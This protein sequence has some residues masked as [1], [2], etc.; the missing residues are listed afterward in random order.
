MEGHFVSQVWGWSRSRTQAHGRSYVSGK[1][2]NT[3]KR[4]VQGK[5]SDAPVVS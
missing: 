4:R 1:L 2:E 5:T 3:V